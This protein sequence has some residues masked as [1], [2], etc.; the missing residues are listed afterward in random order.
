MECHLRVI[1][2]G[3]KSLTHEVEFTSNG[4]RIAHGETTMVCAKNRGIADFE[5]IPLPEE[6]RS[7]IEA[8]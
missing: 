5:S 3:T 4:R 8:P 7:K 2:I 6:I 1:R